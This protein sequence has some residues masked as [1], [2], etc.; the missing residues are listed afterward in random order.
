MKY[1]KNLITKPATVVSGYHTLY[2][3]VTLD[4]LNT[5]GTALSPGARP[6]GPLGMH[7][8]NKLTERSRISG[9][10]Q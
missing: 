8:Q 9:R 5:L 3:E 2:G 1:Q 10:T 6:F 7:G 4:V